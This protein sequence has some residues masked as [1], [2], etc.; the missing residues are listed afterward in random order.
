MSMSVLTDAAMSLSI[1]MTA[2]HHNSTASRYVVTAY[3]LPFL[4]QFCGAEV[5]LL[6]RKGL[7]I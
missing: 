6:I 5:M 2:G 1:I 4:S 7:P 3:R